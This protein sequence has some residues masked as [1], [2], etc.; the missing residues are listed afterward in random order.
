MEFIG[1]LC[2]I[3]ISTTLISHLS[4]KI[5]IPAVIGQLLVGLILGKAGFNVVHPDVIVKEFSEIGII[6]LMFMAGLE[7]NVSLLKKYFKPAIMVASLGVI[8]PII[9]GIFT[10]VGFNL[11]FNEAIFLGIALA[12]TSV[13]ISVDVLKEL[14][15]LNSKEGSTILGAAIVDDILVVFVVSIGLSFLTT[16]SESSVTNLPLVFVEQILYFG[17]IFFLIKWIAPF[18]MNYSSKIKSNS[19]VIIMSL[20]ICLAMSYV[21]DLVGLSSVIGAFF[22]GVAVAQTEVFDEVLKS[23]EEIGYS[24][25]IPVFFVSIGLNVELSDFY[26]QILFILSFTAI[27]VLTKLIGGYIGARLSKFEQNSSLMIGA[28]MISRGEMALIIIQIGKEAEIINNLHY[29]AF[30]IVILLSTLISPL[31][32]KVFAKKIYA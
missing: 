32:L 8:L 2:I 21:A 7:S 1:I 26:P 27:A 11:N 18:I 5:A 16:S 25:F 19:A 9:G 13:S 10:G 6:I 12:A 23:V 20:V 14:N 17:G 22:A 28:G 4:R 15:I 30:I 29:S 3:L 24:I 31:L